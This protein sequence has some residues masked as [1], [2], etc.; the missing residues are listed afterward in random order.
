MVCRCFYWQIE[1]VQ[2]A[3][4]AADGLVAHARGGGEAAV[5]VVVVVGESVVV[6]E[7]NN[8]HATSPPPPTTTTRSFFV[9]ECYRASVGVDEGAQ[10]T[11]DV[12]P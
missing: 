9:S 4:K 8:F 11:A 2:R 5:A 12:P 10:L 7:T 6:E 1:G 3:D